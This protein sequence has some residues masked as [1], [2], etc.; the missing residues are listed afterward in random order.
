MIP[1]YTVN[2]ESKRITISDSIRA[3]DGSPIVNALVRLFRNGV[4]VSKTVKTDAEGKFSL[5]SLPYGDY[6]VEVLANNILAPV[7]KTYILDSDTL[8]GTPLEGV[9]TWDSCEGREGLGYSEDLWY[10]PQ[11][12]FGPGAIW[13]TNGVISHDYYENKTFV[14]N[15]GTDFSDVLAQRAN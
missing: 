9:P 8:T 7:A 1:L 13:H 6:H 10:A 2:D 15:T 11:F 5:D 4:P 14:C 12:G 3:Q